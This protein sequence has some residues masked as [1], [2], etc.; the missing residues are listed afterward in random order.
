MSSFQNSIP[1][2]QGQKNADSQMGIHLTTCLTITAI[3][4]KEISLMA[5]ISITSMTEKINRGLS[6]SLKN[7]S[8]GA[9]Q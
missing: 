1:K 3:K 2:D 5:D 6:G 9:I 4:L 8:N 7:Q